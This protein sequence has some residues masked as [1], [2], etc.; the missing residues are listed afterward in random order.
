ML[1]LNIS[2]STNLVLPIK[3]Y[4]PEKICLVLENREHPLNENHTNKFSVLEN[5]T[6]EIPSSY[7]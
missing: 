4:E 5:P 7:L 1:I 2:V 6:V 3:S